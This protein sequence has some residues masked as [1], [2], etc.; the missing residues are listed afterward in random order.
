MVSRSTC[1]SA[2]D[3]PVYGFLIVPSDDDGAIRVHGVAGTE[4]APEMVQGAWQRTDAGYCMTVGI[5]VPEWSHVRVG[6]RIG[7]DL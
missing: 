3:A 1:A 6:D 7:F 5:A 2:D 4:G